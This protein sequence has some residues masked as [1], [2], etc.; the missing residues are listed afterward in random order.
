MTSHPRPLDLVPEDVLD[1]LVEDVAAGISDDDFGRIEPVLADPRLEHE[2]DEVRLAAAT[3]SLAFA[4]TADAE[5][6]PDR[7][8]LLCLGGIRA[9]SQQDE[10]LRTAPAVEAQPL[11]FSGPSV[12]P[13]PNRGSGVAG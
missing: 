6:M 4:D 13:A 11:R 12:D 10:S 3:A 9:A 2:L 8:R 1:L 7:L 5:P